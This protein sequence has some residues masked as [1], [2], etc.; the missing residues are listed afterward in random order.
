[1]GHE[2]FWDMHCAWWFV[3]KEPL[4]ILILYTKRDIK[5][6][7]LPLL[8]PPPFW[9]LPFCNDWILMY[10]MGLCGISVLNLI[11]LL[12]KICSSGMVSLVVI[13]SLFSS[14][15]NGIE[16]F[17][18]YF[19]FLWVFVVVIVFCQLVGLAYIMDYIV[20]EKLHVPLKLMYP[21]L[22]SCREM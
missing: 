20:V 14:F 21:T 19:S 4:K 10:P 3:G 9:F 18:C 12:A 13:L 11:N 6:L 1:M 7:V 8:P 17:W 15:K 22:Y 5:D 2:L 16:C